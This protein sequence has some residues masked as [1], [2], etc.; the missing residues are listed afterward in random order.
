MNFL[1]HA[2]GL[3]NEQISLSGRFDDRAI[4][5]RTRN[6][7]TRGRQRAKQRRD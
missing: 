2:I 5:T 4:I 1:D 3:E 7:S 6:H